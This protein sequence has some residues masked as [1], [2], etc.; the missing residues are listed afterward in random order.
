MSETLG[1]VVGPQLDGIGNRGADR[2]IEDMLDPNRNVDVAF[3]TTTLALETGKAVS[4]LLRREEGAVFVLINN[5]G[6]EFTVPKKEV[7]ER[8]TSRTSLMPEGL[9]KA[10]S[11]QDFNDL[12]AFLLQQT[13]QVE[14]KK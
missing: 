14:E 13:A 8:L 6:E 7:D 3:Q 1:K 4:G 9:T 11:E 2:V 5:K 12:L 10:F